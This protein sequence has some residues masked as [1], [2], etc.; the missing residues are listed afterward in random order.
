MIGSSCFSVEQHVPE[1]IVRCSGGR[2]PDGLGSAVA[3]CHG[4]TLFDRAGAART[5]LLV[6]DFLAM[7]DTLKLQRTW[8]PVNTCGTWCFQSS[9]RANKQEVES[10]V[11]LQCERP[12]SVA[13]ARKL[14][15]SAE[16]GPE[17]TTYRYYLKVSTVCSCRNGPAQPW[18]ELVQPGG[19]VSQWYRRSTDVPPLR[20]QMAENNWVW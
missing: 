17:K 16:R 5:Q 9:V 4:K 2:G 7:I 1:V 12:A 15:A 11:P 10:R 14:I 20:G 13:T 6:R 19:T 8:L 3:I 18:P